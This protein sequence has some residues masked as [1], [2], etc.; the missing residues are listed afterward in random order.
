[1]RQWAR[2]LAIK[3][4]LEIAEGK[5]EEAIHTIETGMAF[6]RHIAEGPFLINGLVG[7]A[8]ANVMLADVEELIAQPGAPNLYWALTALPSPLFDIR[9]ELETERTLCENLIPELAEAVS[10]EPRTAAEWTSLLARM[11][12]GLIKWSRYFSL[13]ALAPGDLAQHKSVLLPAARDSLKATRNVS[14]QQLAAMSDDQVVA[15]YIA[16]RYHEL[17]DD[18]FKAGYLPLKDAIPQIAAAQK[19]LAGRQIGPA[20]TVDHDLAIDRVRDDEPLENRSSH[21]RAARDRGPAAPRRG[22]R[23]QARRVARPDHRGARPQGPG[24]E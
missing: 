4:R 3:A 5:Y 23:R 19:Q 24:D 1:M 8:V 10:S 2:L 11:E 20:G 6:A 22:A 21:R 12:Q 17:W 15:L 13:K 7:M 16:G 14:D 18:F 9:H